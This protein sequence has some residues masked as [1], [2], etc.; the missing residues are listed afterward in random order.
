[1]KQP[2]VLTIVGIS[3]D[4]SRRYLLP[5]IEKLASGGNLPEHFKIIG[6]TRQPDLTLQDVLPDLPADNFIIKNT[7]MCHVDLTKL[8][9]YQRLKEHIEAFEKDFGSVAQHLFHLSVPPLVAQPVVELLGESGLSGGPDT[10][11]LLEKPFGDDLASAEEFNQHLIKFFKENQVYRIDHYLAKNIAQQLINTQD[12]DPS[13]INAVSVVASEAIGVEGRAVFYEQTGALKDFVQS[14]LLQLAAL[15]LMERNST[16]LSDR[17]MAA[18]QLLH[19][20]YNQPIVDVVVR[21]QYDTYQEEVKNPGST[22]ETFVSLKLQTEDP[23]WKDVPIQLTTGKA[24]D[25]KITQVVLKTDTGDQI[26]TNEDGK[27][28]E[29]YQKLFL[30]AITGQRELFVTGPEVLESW[31]ILQPIEQAWEM[32]SKD[33][34]IYK[35]GSSPQNV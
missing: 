14:H 3:G 32:S 4:L 26:I 35:S 22:T 1:M 33:L 17:R 13:K 28:P 29:A 21:G 19:L 15:T 10:K 20:P 9:D 5:A 16:P 12:I 34:R 2:T 30:D 6:V 11:L 24:L 23:R 7:E 25:K 18:L 31:R 27:S 8:A